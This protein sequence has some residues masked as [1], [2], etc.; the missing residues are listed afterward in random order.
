MNQSEQYHLEL[1]ASHFKEGLQKK[2]KSQLAKQLCMNGLPKTTGELPDLFLKF[3]AAAAVL[4]KKAIKEAHQNNKRFQEYEKELLTFQ[5]NLSAV[6]AQ[7]NTPTIHA[8]LDGYAGKQRKVPVQGSKERLEDI[9]AELELIAKSA[10]ESAGVSKFKRE[11]SLK[12]LQEYVLSLANFYTGISGE[13]FKIL[14]HKD[15]NTDLY[16]PVK[17]SHEFIWDAVQYL[18]ACVKS[19]GCNRQYTDKNIYNA[20]EAAQKMLKQTSPR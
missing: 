1:M 16:K 13:D 11:T 15:S 18:N 7:S 20:F 9:F 6:V 17:P 4:K 19:E 2:V 5:K 8:F 3:S 10:G 14:R 12:A